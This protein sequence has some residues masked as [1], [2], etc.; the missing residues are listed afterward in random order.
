MY[1]VMKFELIKKVPIVEIGGKRCFLDTG[2]PHASMPVAQGVQ[3][4]FGIPGLHFAGVQALKRYTKFDYYNNEIT[5]SDEPISL[6]GGTAVPL[7][8]RPTGWL[9]KMTVGGVEG[10]RYIDTGAAFSYVHNISKDFPSGGTADECAF[11]GR[12]WTAPM[13]RVP[14]EFAGHQFE[15][16]CGD[17]NDNPEY[18]PPEGVIG[19]DFFAN[20]T[21]VVDR[22]GGKMVKQCNEISGACNTL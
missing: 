4:F 8:V 18:V 21:L 7:E 10:M 19:Y 1:I 22:V 2:Y 12:P 14:C 13:R 17:A 5:T 16:L 15:I 20:F 11:D 9:V 3:E 6:E